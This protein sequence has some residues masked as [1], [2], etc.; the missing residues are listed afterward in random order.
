MINKNEPLPD[1][2][3]KDYY[4][5]Y[6]KVVLEELYPKEFLNLEITDKPDLE[7]KN[8]EY[9]IEVTNARDKDQMNAENLYSRIS[10]NKVRNVTRALEKIKK[11]GCKLE[12]GILS[13]KVGTDSFDLIL[14]A[15]NKKL[16][17][18]NRKGYRYFKRNCLF[19]FS[20]IYA[21][22]KMITKAVKDMQQSQINTGKNFYKVFVWLP[23]CFCCLNL[24]TGSYEIY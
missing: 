15:F 14:S 8:G 9:G 1:H 2:T 21:D 20:D 24:Y 6:A 11:C 13:G 7:T 16:K 18:L 19:I 4:E 23:K 22:D 3:N 10:Y 17:K 5:C 12:G